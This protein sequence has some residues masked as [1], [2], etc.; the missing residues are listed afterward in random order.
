M[1]SF[2]QGEQ[3]RNKDFNKYK[4]FHTH[5]NLFDNRTFSFDFDFL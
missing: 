1:T 3:S 5:E 4:Y 2:L